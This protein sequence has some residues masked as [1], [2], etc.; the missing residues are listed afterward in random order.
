MKHVGIMVLIVAVLA[1]FAL[2]GCSWLGGGDAGKPADARVVVTPS[3]CP[4]AK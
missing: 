2:A 1:I 3:A 4:V